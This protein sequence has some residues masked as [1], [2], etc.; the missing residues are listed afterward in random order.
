MASRAARPKESGAGAE[1]A[2]ARF[3]SAAE[4]HGLVDVA[5]ATLDTEIGGLLLAATPRGLVRVVLPGLDH[6]DALEA[7]SAEVSPRILSGSRRLDAPMRQLEEF[8]AGRRRRFELDLDE[9][10]IRGFHRDVL[11]LTRAI[12]Y[13][14]VVTY[15]RLAA[16]AGRPRAA[17]AAGTALARNPIP[18]VIPCHR[19]VPAAGGVGQYGGGSETK[20][21]LLELEGVEL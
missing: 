9:Q 13:G 1:R 19:V 3:A 14:E 16:D 4:D 12:A 6:G 2:I 8:L 10:L 20:R 17:R 21:R 7:L 5:T 15:G 11:R 18:L